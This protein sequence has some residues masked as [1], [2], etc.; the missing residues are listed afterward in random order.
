MDYLK[1][2]DA[3]KIN[4]RRFEDLE[5]PELKGSIRL[6]ELTAGRSLEFKKLQVKREKG[7]DVERQQMVLMLSAVVDGDGKPLFPDDKAAGKFIDT[8]SF[9]TLELIA[10][11]VAAMMLPKKEE[12]GDAPGN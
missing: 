5:V 8:V 2:E 1:L 10:S 4:G 6:A 11:K 12:G 3:M 7:E 9:K